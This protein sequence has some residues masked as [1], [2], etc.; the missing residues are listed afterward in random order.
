MESPPIKILDGRP[1]SRK[2]LLSDC[3]KPETPLS[4]HQPPLKKTRGLPNLTE[5]QACGFRSDNASSKKQIQTLYS[6]WRIV[7]LCPKCYN[8]VDSSQICAYCFKEA[9][10][11]CFSC[12]LCKRSLH[13]TCFLDYKSVPPWSYAVCGSEFTVCIDCWVPE[14]IASKRGIFRREKNAKISCVSEVKNGGV[15]KLLDVVKDANCAMGETVE[16]AVEARGMALNINKAD[17]AQQVVEFANIEL[18]KCDDAELA[19]RMH[20]AMNSSPRISKNR[21]LSDDIRLDALVAGSSRAFSCLKPTEIVYARRRKKP[22]KMEP[23]DTVYA[24]YRKKPVQIVYARRRKNPVQIVYA[25]RR[26]KACEIADEQ[27]I[28]KHNEMVYVQPGK[29]QYKLVYKRRSKQSDSKEKSDVEIGPKEREDGC[30]NFLSKSGV[31]TKMNSESKAYNYEDDAIV[32]DNMQSDGKLV[33]YLL[34]YSR[35]KSKWKGTPV[36]KTEFFYDGYNRES[37]ASSSQLP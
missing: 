35:K 16:A 28:I 1:T 11:D 10:E 27:C 2:R 18:E 14:K 37:Q 30:S 8:R 19:F 33:Q 17:V 5:C 36:D 29:K 31:D 7:L 4:L 15:V 23:R 12:T 25:R 24:S 34:T 22:N 20:K 3:A 21:N 6:E 32:F 13:K 9:S 26:K